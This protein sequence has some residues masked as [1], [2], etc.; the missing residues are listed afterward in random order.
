MRC[1]CCCYS[2]KHW[3]GYNVRSPMLH[4]RLQRRSLVPSPDR[5]NLSL[6]IAAVSPPVPLCCRRCKTSKPGAS[7]AL[8]CSIQWWPQHFF[9]SLSTPL[10]PCMICRQTTF[11]QH[12]AFHMATLNRHYVC[13]CRIR[14]YEEVYEPIDDR[15]F[16]YIKLIDMVTGDLYIK[17]G[18]QT[19]ESLHLRAW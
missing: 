14:K 13:C 16:H 19:A 9:A 10:H 2:Y 15:S 5:F 3:L 18:Q 12:A 4:Q 1:V 8:F 7:F 6:H 11:P 17:L